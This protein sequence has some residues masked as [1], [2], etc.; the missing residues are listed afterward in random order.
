MSGLKKI[1]LQAPASVIE[2]ME[3]IAK[4]NERKLSAEVRIAIREYV[5]RHEAEQKDAA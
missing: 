4:T 5:E 3:K 2:R 1:S